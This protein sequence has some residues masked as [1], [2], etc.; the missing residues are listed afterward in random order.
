MKTELSI[1]IIGRNEEAGIERCVTAAKTAAQQVGSAE[2]LYVDS[3]STD[4]TVEIA[5]SLGAKI[6][7]LPGHARLCPSLGRN[8]GSHAAHGEFILFLDADTIVYED[9]LPAALAHLRNKPAVAGVNGRIDDLDEKGHLI[10]DYEDRFQELAEVKWLRGPACL[11]RREALQQAGT[12]DADLA[13][14]EEAELGLR[15][16]RAGWH[17]HLLPIRMALH[18]RCYHVNTLAGMLRTFARDY[19]AGR[20]GEITRTIGYAFRAG[21]GVE[22][23]WLRLKTTLQ[24]LVWVAATV[25]LA[26]AVPVPW[27]IT[28]SI[29]LIVGH[30][31]IM[32]RKRSV[33]Q[34]LLFI[35]NKI[36]N[37]IDTAMGIHKLWSVRKNFLEP[38]KKNRRID[39]PVLAIR[40]K[41]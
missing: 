10:P 41:G 20:L 19:R 18:T 39:A 31:A 23:C 29:S 22:F 8:V 35:P 1:V 9:F 7:Q 12:F 33:S 38:P 14:E 30:S 3:A 25:L 36:L 16:R 37:L 17:L 11:Y 28:A 15:L 2:I 32:Y 27:W 24:F 4:R 5:A 21:T 13:M 40:H 26:A 6:I 34:A